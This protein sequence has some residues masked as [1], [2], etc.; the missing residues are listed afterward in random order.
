MR[1]ESAAPVTVVLLLF[2]SFVI[3]QCH[4]YSLFFESLWYLAHLVSYLVFSDDGIPAHG[5]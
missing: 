1:D 5:M 4:W 2:L 3:L